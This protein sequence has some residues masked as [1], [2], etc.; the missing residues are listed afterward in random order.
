M[1]YFKNRLKEFEEIYDPFEIARAPPYFHAIP[2]I[3][4]NDIE[5][6][7]LAAIKLGKGKYIIPEGNNTIIINPDLDENKLNQLNQK[8]D[9]NGTKIIRL[10]KK[11]NSLEKKPFKSYQL[12]AMIY[13]IF[14]NRKINALDKGLKTFYHFGIG[15]LEQDKQLYDKV[16]NH[17]ILKGLNRKLVIKKMKDSLQNA[18]QN[19][20]TR[21]FPTL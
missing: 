20:W 15:F 4:N 8:N 14:K 1:N 19:K 3:F 9:G 5:L 12:E 13:E 7:C 21:V 10:L 6:D 17:P 2:A 16:D 18:Q 11:W